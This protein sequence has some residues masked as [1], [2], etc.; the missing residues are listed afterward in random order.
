MK[1]DKKAK[2]L[3]AAEMIMSQKGG[4]EATISEIAAEAGVGDSVIYQYYRSKEALLFSIPRERMKEVLRL[5]EE[6]LEGIRDAESRLAKM[7]WFHL[8]HNDLH[9]GYSRILLLECRTSKDF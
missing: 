5:L 7:I 6:Q 1:E 9:P 4:S 8:K 3:A 2:I